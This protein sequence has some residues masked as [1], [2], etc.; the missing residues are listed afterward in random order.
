MTTRTLIDAE[1]LEPLLG[2]RRLR[3]FDCRFDLARPESGR[4]R[5]LDEHLP[6]AI[7]ADLN[8]D[9]SRPATPTS[10]RHPLPAPEVFAARL[11]EWGVNDD[12][13]VVAYDD[14]NGMYAARLWWMLRWLGHDDAAVLDGGMRRWIQLGLPTSDEVPATAAR[15]LRRAA[16]TRAR[17]GRRRGAARRARPSHAGPRCAGAG[18]LPR[19]G[20]ADRQSRRARPGRAQPP[21]HAQPRRPGSLPAARATAHGARDTSRRRCTGAHHRLLR[22]GRHCLPPAARHGA[23]RPRGRTP[24]PGLV[25]RVVERSGAPGSDRPGALTG[26][27][28][29]RLS[30]ADASAI[31]RATFSGPRS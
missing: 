14:G 9:L 30:I 22:V 29:R 2:S 15:Q 26:R 3:L 24:L 4:Q 23:R 1:A 10:G 12:S 8:R 19:R 13:L 21:V 25:E 6:G 5:Y 27:P 17:G 16:A 18:A 20:R 28:Q 31:V 7:Y 11:R